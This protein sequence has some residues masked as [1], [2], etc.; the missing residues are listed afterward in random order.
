MAAVLR[1]VLHS[2]R[3][4]VEHVESASETKVERGRRGTGGKWCSQ[5]K[6]VDA[7]DE[8]EE[9]KPISDVEEDLRDTAARVDSELGSRCKTLRQKTRHGQDMSADRPRKS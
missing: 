9:E 8:F 1:A 5:R 3:H 6:G 7:R 2:S 4:L